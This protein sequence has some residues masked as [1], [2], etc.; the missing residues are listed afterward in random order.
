MENTVKSNI[1]PAVLVYESAE[2]SPL[3][4]SV[5]ALLAGQDVRFVSMHNREDLFK[6]APG[7][8]LI[9]LSAK[10]PGD[11]SCQIAVAMA[12]N[13]A[14]TSD[15]MGFAPNAS[16]EERVKFLTYGFDYAFNDEF[17]KFP[18]FRQVILKK[19][20]KGYLRRD[21][22]IQEEEYRR[23][24]ASLSASP[25]AFIVLDENKKIFFVSHHYKRAYPLSANKLVR[26][27]D[28]SDAFDMLSQEQGVSTSDPRYTTLKNFWERL[29]GTQEF[30]T[31]D[32]RV[33]RMKASRLDDGQGTIITTTD[34]TLYLR[35]KHE[36]EKTSADLE[37]ALKNEQ[38]ASALQ[39]QFVN[40]VSH[41]FRTPLTVIDGHAQILHRKADEIA[42]DDI[43]KRAKTIRS[44]VSRLISMMEGVLSSNMLKT[45]KLE[46][47]PELVNLKVF[48]RDLCDD[49]MELAREHQITLDCES[50][51]E[52]INVDRKV[53]S[54]ILTNLLSNAIKYT[55]DKPKITVY[56]DVRDQWL[57]IQVKDNGIG[58]PYNELPRIFER[59]FRASTASGIPGTG[60]GLSL[61]K[62][63]VELYQ[64]KLEVNSDIGRG[65]EFLV[66]LPITGR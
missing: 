33:W 14:V 66:S 49:H 36:L 40:M 41:E 55:K 1:K 9:I 23:F 2:D 47:I 53:V 15:L 10:Y 43:R 46:I 5:W 62:D 26:G 18:D 51:P 29:E 27:L 11:E 22:R 17:M 61:V 6:E 32:G 13:P 48:A 52:T 57:N 31:I 3:G 45:G 25:D 50:L 30:E 39:K 28:I 19:I 37:G 64:G 34:I 60:I 20:E 24:R 54:L 16:V 21:S 4:K 7:A 35:Q 12:G 63:L 38:E 59:Y 42:P 58:I 65:T 8:A 44:A 56:L